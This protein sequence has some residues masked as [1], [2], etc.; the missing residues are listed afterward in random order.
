MKIK[1]NQMMMN[2]KSMFLSY[3]AASVCNYMPVFLNMRAYPTY[4]FIYVYELLWYFS[5]FVEEEYTLP[6][7]ETLED[8]DI[9]ENQDE[10][11]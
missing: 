11:N 4:Y 1:S 5:G 10:H 8:R 7:P 3:R 9:E 6:L 2:E